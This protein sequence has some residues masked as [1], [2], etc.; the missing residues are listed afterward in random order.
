MKTLTKKAVKRVPSW[1]ELK[2]MFRETDRKF[3]ETDRKFQE[4]DRKS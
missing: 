4:T 2:E 3:Q 1:D